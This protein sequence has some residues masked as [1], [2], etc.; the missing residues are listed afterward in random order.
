MKT[1][2][3]SLVLIAVALSGCATTN[4]NI[5]LDVGGEITMGQLGVCTG[6]ATGAHKIRVRN[7]YSNLAHT[8][9]NSKADYR[10]FNDGVARGYLI[11][12][13]E[14]E[15]YPDAMGRAY[16]NVV[17]EFDCGQFNY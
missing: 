13:G 12:L 11:V 17:F 16:G 10:A 3:M 2:F 4:T 8:I 7:D 9:G 15:K 14:L 1:T 5:N 6:I